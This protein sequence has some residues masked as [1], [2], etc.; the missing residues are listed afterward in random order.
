MDSINQNDMVDYCEYI[1]QLISRHSQLNLQN[2]VIDLL[3]AKPDKLSERESVDC[4]LEY[5]FDNLEIRMWSLALLSMSWIIEIL[6]RKTQDGH[7]HNTNHEHGEKEPRN[8]KSG[9]DFH[10]QMYKDCL[11]SF[12]EVINVA[13]NNPPKELR[14]TGE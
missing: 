2:F 5:K 11:S 12:R 7:C 8:C 9:Y 3:N 4:K 6:K 13:E 14:Q 1:Q 10:L